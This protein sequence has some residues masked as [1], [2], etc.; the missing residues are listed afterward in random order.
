MNFRRL[1]LASQSP[2]RRQ[3]LTISGYEFDILPSQISEIPDENLNLTSRIRQL[4]SEK[5]HACLKLRKSTEE[6]GFLFLAADT[7]VVLGDQILGKPK[8]EIEAR[9][10]L[11][12]LSGRSHS[13]IT[14]ISLVDGVS[15]KETQGHAITEVKFKEL[16]D[17]QITDYIKSG[18]PFDKAGGYG[19]QGE[20]AKFIDHLEGPYDNVVG[21]PME[22]VQNALLEMGLAVDKKHSEISNGLNLIRSR[23]QSSA[24]QSGRNPQEVELIAVSKTKPATDVI[25]AWKAGQRHFGE[26][27]AQEATEK[28]K[29]VEELIRSVEAPIGSAPLESKPITWHFIGNLQSKKVKSIVG[30][31]DYIHSVDRLSLAE[32]ISKRAVARGIE[33]KILLQLNFGD[34]TTKSGASASEYLELAEIVSTLPGIQLCGLMALPPLRESPEASRDQFAAIKKI[35]GATQAALRAKKPSATADLFRELSMGTT[36]DFEQAVIEGATMIR[37]GTAIF[38][39]RT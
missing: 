30:I 26:N 3:I 22:Q 38:G 35:F 28:I 31:F 23:I 10:F 33:Q 12:R 37:V 14:A 9:S 29:D 7:V 2:R 11:R 39:E 8:D 19:I 25:E 18:E 32:E 4:A 15:G 6:Q 20:A 27:Y 17:E 24:K 36:G 34:E 13:V 5:A 21:L 16:T 1:V